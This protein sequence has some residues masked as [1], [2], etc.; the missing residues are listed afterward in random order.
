MNKQRYLAELRR[1]LVFMT[2]EDRDRTVRRYGYMFD[3]VGPEGEAKLLAEIGS[4]T[5][6]AIGLSRG[7]E[8]GSVKE[9]EPIPPAAPEPAPETV[10]P[11]AE[12][13]GEPWEDIPNYR[14]PEVPEATAAESGE[15]PPADA[16]S[17]EAR[18]SVPPEAAEAPAQTLPE[19]APEI[20]PGEDRNALPEEIEAILEEAEEA[21]EKP[22]YSVER[23]MSL[24]LGIPLFILVMVALGIPI[25][26]LFLALAV[27]FLVPGCAVLFGAWLIFVGGLW[28]MGIMA[29]AILLFGVCAIV[30]ALGLILL[31][32]GLW[33]DVIMIGGYGK[34]VRWLSGE[35][36]GRRVRADE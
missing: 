34:A 19:E 33:L 23:S 14:P 7:Y 32:L 4:P 9:P 27:V 25:A 22:A 2:D 29:D 13:V 6:A 30:L 35:L 11:Q 1:L 17:D 15:T 5:K 28:C 18:E 8:P 3:A 21:A 20:P 12:S 36:L 16:V 26:A 31:F 10:A 24:W